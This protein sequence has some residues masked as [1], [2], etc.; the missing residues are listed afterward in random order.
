[1]IPES[2]AI[3][4]PRTMMIHLQIASVASRAMVT[5]FRLYFLAIE[6]VAIQFE[7]AVDVGIVIFSE[8]RSLGQESLLVLRPQ[9]GHLLHIFNQLLV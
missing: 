4:N 8:F 3:R 1:M 7:F 6:A 9:K 2:D 5:T